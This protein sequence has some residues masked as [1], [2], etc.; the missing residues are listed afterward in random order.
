M[1]MEKLYNYQVK[2]MRIRIMNDELG[3]LFW[4][5]THSDTL[6]VIKLSS[7]F[8]HFLGVNILLLANCTRLYSFKIHRKFLE[9]IFRL[10]QSMQ[11]RNVK[12]G[13]QCI[14][15]TNKVYIW[16]ITIK[17]IGLHVIWNPTYFS[18]VSTYKW[19]KETLKWRKHD[20]G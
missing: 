17:S 19:I 4:F 13:K 16:T 9:V 1:S 18:V 12:S 15:M 14:Q 3:Q 20:I 11:L 8:L 2:I 6:Y 7:R 10:F 5:T